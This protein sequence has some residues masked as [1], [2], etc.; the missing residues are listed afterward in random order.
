M[1]IKHKIGFIALITLVDIFVIV[2]VVMNNDK[3]NIQ[4]DVKTKTS[5]HILEAPKKEVTESVELADADQVEESTNEETSNEVI[6]ENDNNPVED[7]KENINNPVEEN[8]NNKSY[9]DMTIEE[10]EAA[11]NDGTLVLE[12]SGLYTNTSDKL[13][14]SRGVY[15]F[16]G[17]KETYYD[18]KTLPGTG[19]V[20]P[21]RHV[22]EDGTIRDQ[23][24][25]ICVAANQA[26]M[27]KGTILITSLGPAKVYDTGCA[28]GTI[29]IYVNW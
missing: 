12:Y 22:A 21:G 11:L 19:L 26:Y 16:N 13:T 14:K 27:A 23:D 5:A 8:I 24:G 10:K 1:K 15:N 9:D 18:E 29:D 7:N 4:N 3:T 17:H 2:L 25:Y 20:I 6:K 28:Y